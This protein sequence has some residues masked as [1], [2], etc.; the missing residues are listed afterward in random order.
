MSEQGQKVAEFIG[1]PSPEDRLPLVCLWAKRC[2]EDGRTVAVHVGDPGEAERLDEMMWTFEDRA[3]VPHVRAAHADPPVIEP[4][5][6]H[7]GDEPLAEAD[8]LIE[9]AG[10]APNE[11]ALR[12]AHVYDFAEVY[13]ENL[14]LLSRERYKACQDAGYHMRF[15]K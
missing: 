8:V 12:F 5:L 9:A 11:R 3:F 10:G 7:C 1:L 13:D 14:R 6:I 15:I 4:V 2:C